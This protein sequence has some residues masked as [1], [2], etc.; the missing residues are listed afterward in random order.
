M[1]AGAY[2]NL[3]VIQKLSV[4]YDDLR[5][6]IKEWDDWKKVYAYA[7]AL[8][9][10]ERWVASQTHSTGIVEFICRW[11]VL[12]DSMNTTEYRILFRNELYDIESIDNIQFRNNTVKIRGYVT[13]GK[14]D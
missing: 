7:N 14:S 10:T 8:S 9:G 3:I 11:N 1:E 12:F 13:H 4:I 2:R 5:N 6:P